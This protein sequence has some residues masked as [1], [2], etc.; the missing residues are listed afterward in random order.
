LKASAKEL[1][2]EHFKL[3]I[4]KRAEVFD[5]FIIHLPEANPQV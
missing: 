4:G 3:E 5:S 1:K 2:Y